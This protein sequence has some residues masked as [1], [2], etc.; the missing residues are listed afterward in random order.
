MLGEAIVGLAMRGPDY[1]ASPPDLDEFADVSGS[2]IRSI[3]AQCRGGVRF[4]GIGDD[5]TQSVAA[6]PAISARTARGSDLPRC[7]GTPGH[8]RGDNFSRR[9]SA[10]T[11]EHTFAASSDPVVHPTMGMVRHRSKI[12]PN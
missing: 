5:G 2:G 10:Q 11:H 12:D 1:R 7:E 3:V 8:H 6:A 9:A 4:N